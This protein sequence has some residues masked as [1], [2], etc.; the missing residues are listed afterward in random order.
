MGADEIFHRKNADFRTMYD[1]V[2]TDFND[3]ANIYMSSIAHRVLFEI[4]Y[5]NPESPQK[6]GR[7]K[8]RKIKNFICNKPFLYLVHDTKENRILFMGRYGKPK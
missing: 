3:Y 8:P 7:K 6:S 5:R 4:D 1:L 2:C